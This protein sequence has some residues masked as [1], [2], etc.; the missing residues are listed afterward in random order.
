MKN[1][2]LLNIY[3][4]NTV[5]LMYPKSIQAELAQYLWFGYVFFNVFG[6]KVGDTKELVEQH[7]QLLHLESLM[8]VGI[9]GC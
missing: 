3:S 2:I 4:E 8:L 7:D 1:G 9:L 6:Y 5:F